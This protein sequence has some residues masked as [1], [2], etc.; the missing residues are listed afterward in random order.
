[1]AEGRAATLHER[2]LHH[3]LAAA[4][5]VEQERG[6][7]HQLPVVGVVQLGEIDPRGVVPRCGW[8]SHGRHHRPYGRPRGGIGGHGSLPH[9]PGKVGRWAGS[10]DLLLPHRCPV[11]LRPGESPCPA[12]RRRPGRRRRRLPPPAGVDR[13]VAAVAYRGEGRA[14][15]AAVK[16]RGDRGPLPWLAEVL[17]D[18]LASSSASAVARHVGAGHR[19]PPPQREASTARS[20]SPGPSPPSSDGPCA[21]CCAAGPGRRRWGAT[22]SP[23]GAGRSSTA[24]RPLTGPVLVV[25]DVVTTGGTATAGGSGPAVGRCRRGVVRRHRPHVIPVTRGAQ[26]SRDGSVVPM[27]N[28]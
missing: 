14:V 12:C 26:R 16:F 20:C 1:M 8:C 11:C 25:D 3:L 7:A 27:N 2:L 18:E 5:V 13:C 23:A 4:D 19:A 24:R 15:V 28:R 6:Q 21:G 17:V 10:R 22:R 9:P